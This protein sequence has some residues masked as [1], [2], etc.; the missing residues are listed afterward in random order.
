M[1]NSIRT[2]IFL[3]SLLFADVCTNAQ[4]FQWAQKMGNVKSDKITSVKTD[5]SGHIYVAGYFSSNITIGTNGVVVNFVGN[6]SS[7]EA[8]IAKLDSTGF[9]LWAKAG[10]AYF[11]DRILGM[12]V[13]S[14]GYSV[15]T[16]TFWEGSGINFPP[17]NVTGSGFGSGDQCFIVKFDPN[18]NP[19]WGQ[20]VCSRSFGD[21]QGLDVAIDKVG[22]IYTVGF[23]TSD[24]LYC[25]GKTLT[26]VNPNSGS[27][28]H[29][30]W[31]TKMN[32][33]GVFQWARPLAIYHGIQQPTS[34]LSVTLPFVSIRQTV[35][36]L[37]VALMVRGSLVQVPSYRPEVMI[38]LL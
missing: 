3:L 30:Y 38:A 14:A 25:G 23:M 26:A 22:N 35:F 11:D 8:F 19:L 33:N 20:F 16:G 32:A 36:T 34:M 4:S 7:K 24:T 17:I 13:D 29:C 15:I 5:G 9:C 18:G 31:L 6:A 37:L 12:D 1:H 10:G 28:K 21:D 27:H 2:I